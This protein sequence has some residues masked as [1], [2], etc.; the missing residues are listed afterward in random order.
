[1]EYLPDRGF[2][3]RRL[4][5]IAGVLAA[6]VLPSFL[7]DLPVAH[8]R[9]SELVPGDLHRCLGWSELFAHGYGVA[10]IGL[11]VF[12]LDVPRRAHVPRLLASAYSAG[13][14]ANLVKLTVARLRPRYFHLD[15]GVLDT[16]VGVAPYLFGGSAQHSHAFEIQSFPSGHTAT[17]VGLAIGLTRLYPRG[18]WLFFTFAA[19]AAWQRIDVQAHFVSDVVAAAAVGFLGAALVSDGSRLGRWFDDLETQN[20]KPPTASAVASHNPPPLD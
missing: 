14:L 9:I 2:S 5:G 15:G 8:S 17:A 3:A 7:L 11:T 18:R 12:V 6:L 10:L 1:M 4:C 16:F 19:L 13:L 20:V